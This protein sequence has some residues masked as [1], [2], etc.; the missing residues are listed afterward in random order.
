MVERW[1]DAT[2]SESRRGFAGE[3]HS[4]VSRGR[5]LVLVAAAL[6]G[7]ASDVHAQVRELHYDLRVD[8]PLLVVSSA[9]LIGSEVARPTLA[10]KHCRWCETNAD[11]GDGVNPLDDAVRDALRWDDMRLAN[12]LSSVIAYGVV[13]ATSLGLLAL[14]Q[15]HDDASANFLIDVI[16]IAEAVTLS[17]GL[18]QVV[19]FAVGRERPHVHALPQAEKAQTASPSNN[20]TS[21][22]SGHTNFAFS[23]AVAAGTVATLR[24]YRWAGWVWATGLALATMTGYLRIASDS[25]YLTDVV[26]GAWTAGAISVAVPVLLHRPLEANGIS[27]HVSG[28]PSGF[29]VSLVWSDRNK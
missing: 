13:P 11:G 8:I 4:G 6:F 27:M 7:F 17:T 18:T 16:A 19:K 21:F 15:W 25:H 28:V 14:A 9:W 10:P 3:G 5:L 20:Y 23:L 2:L 22:F 1:T 29:L 26:F 12:M 24:H